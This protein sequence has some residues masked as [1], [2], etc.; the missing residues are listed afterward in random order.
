MR[1]KKL[2]LM[3]RRGHVGELKKLTQIF[4]YLLQVNIITIMPMHMQNSNQ[5]TFPE[6]VAD[7]LGPAQMN[8]AAASW[9]VTASALYLVFIGLVWVFFYKLLFHHK[10]NVHVPWYGFG[11]FLFIITTLFVFV[12]IASLITSSITLS[13]VNQKEHK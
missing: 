8:S 12:A 4:L 1:S 9:T 2:Y 11:I 7:F 13:N 3:G 10:G 6:K 5:P